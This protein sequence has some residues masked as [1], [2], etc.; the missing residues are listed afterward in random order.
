MLH[1]AKL[2]SL[3]IHLVQVLHLVGF[4]F[5]PYLNPQL[6]VL[7]E[8]LIFITVTFSLLLLVLQANT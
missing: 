8:A 2:V 6:A 1:I 5:I 3:L 4:K 7:Q